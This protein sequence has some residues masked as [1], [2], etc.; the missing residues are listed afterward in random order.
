MKSNRQVLRLLGV[1]AWNCQR[2]SNRRLLNIL[3]GKQHVKPSRRQRMAAKE[4]AAHPVFLIPNE[5]ECP[6]CGKWG[7][8]NFGENKYYCG[9][10]P[11]CCP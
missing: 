11:W 4:I 6:G 8:V 10:T 7:E 1:T 3:S 9:G 5:A 2:I